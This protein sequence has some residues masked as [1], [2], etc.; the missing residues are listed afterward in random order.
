MTID[1]IKSMAED[2]PNRWRN[3]YGYQSGDVVK[4]K[5]SGAIM[6]VL[7]TLPSGELNLKDPRDDSRQTMSAAAVEPVETPT[8]QPESTDEV[9][10]NTPTEEDIIS[11]DEPEIVEPVAEIPAEEAVVTEDA[12]SD[13]DT[14]DD[15]D[16][17]SAT[18]Q[19]GLFTEVEVK[20][21]QAPA[22]TTPAA[23]VLIPQRPQP[24][25]SYAGLEKMVERFGSRDKAL[26]AIDLL[27]DIV[28]EMFPE[29]EAV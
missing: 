22:D 24:A 20:L 10:A 11:T 21:D 1:L 5:A 27:T 26:A 6:E 7:K 17:T 13:D 16:D 19:S 29:T 12:K 2:D 25:N 18:R 23:P 3:K 9:E 14:E 8:Q 4:V 15:A 28:N